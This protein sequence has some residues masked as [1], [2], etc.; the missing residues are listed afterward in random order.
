[1][2]VKMKIYYFSLYH[3]LCVLSCIFHIFA[4]NKSID[5]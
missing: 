1:M 2:V 4:Q 5:V 3:F